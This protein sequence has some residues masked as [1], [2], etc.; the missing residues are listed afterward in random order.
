MENLIARL[1]L[2]EAHSQRVEG[3]LV[4]THAGHRT[5]ATRLLP[6]RGGR[7]TISRVRSPLATASRYSQIASRCQFH[8][9]AVVGSM[10]CQAWRTNSANE[11][12]ASDW[13]SSARLNLR[14]F[15]RS[16]TVPSRE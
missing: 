7:L 12:C 9:S 6:E 13:S 10:I 1:A 4:H 11:S 14:A 3:S 16:K 15:G 8:I 2:Y 5:E